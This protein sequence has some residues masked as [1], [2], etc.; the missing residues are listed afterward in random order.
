MTK[1]PPATESGNKQDQHDRADD[2]WPMARTPTV[3]FTLMTLNA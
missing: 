1:H 2:P 3:L